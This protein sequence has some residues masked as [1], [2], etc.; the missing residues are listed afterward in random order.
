MYLTALEKEWLLLDELNFHKN[1]WEYVSKKGTWQEVFVAFVQYNTSYYLLKKLKKDDIIKN[2]YQQNKRIALC[3]SED[4]WNGKIQNIKSSIYK[5]KEDFYV[6]IQKSYVFK[7]GLY[8]VVTKIKNDDNIAIIFLSENPFIHFE[9]RQEQKSKFYNP[10]N[11][12]IMDHYKIHFKGK[13]SKDNVEILL[14]NEYK[15]LSYVIPLREISTLSLVILGLY[16]YDN[17]L[18]ISRNKTKFLE[19]KQEIEEI[20]NQILDMRK[21]SLLY[22]ETKLLIERIIPFLDK[23]NRNEPQLESVKNLFLKYRIK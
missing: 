11:D 6:E 5:D 17:L 12:L 9:E 21:K 7:G 4:N 16:Y 22:K 1:L 19:E 15:K 20:K 2:Y 8:L 23:L 10:Q 13:I 3:V 18:N 14:L